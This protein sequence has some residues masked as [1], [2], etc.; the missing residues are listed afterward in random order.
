MD[1]WAA[2][3]KRDGRVRRSTSQS[4]NG[5]VGLP[6]SGLAKLESAHWH[7]VG[8]EGG[9]NKIPRYGQWR[10]EVSGSL[11]VIEEGVVWERGRHAAGGWGMKWPVASESGWLTYDFEEEL[12][13]LDDLSDM[14]S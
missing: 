1:D 2:E 5:G 10:K 12:S 6:L 9:S 13:E 14:N 11:I 3:T 7:N 4:I 8:S